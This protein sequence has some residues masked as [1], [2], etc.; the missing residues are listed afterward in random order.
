MNR[1]KDN[2]L[3]FYKRYTPQGLVNDRP[4]TSSTQLILKE[5]RKL[6]MKVEHLIGTNVFKLTYK[7]KERNFHFQNPSSNSATSMFISSSKRAT[8]NLLQ[9]NGIS[10]PKGFAIK[11]NDPASFKKEVY[12]ALQKP[13]VVKPDKGTQGKAISVGINNFSEYL[14]ALKK[15][16]NFS[17]QKDA[18]IVVEEQL[19]GYEEYRV[20]TTKQ[21]VI[22][23]IKR[24]PA[25]IVGDGVSNIRKLIKN[26]NLDP[27]RGDPRDHPPLFRID[28]DVE[29]KEYLNKQN[30]TW[31]TVPPKGQMIQLR[32]VSNISMGGD[33]IDYT[34]KVHNS[35]KTI[36]L[37]AV[38]AIP[39]LELGG[40]DFMS[41][42]ITK[43]QTPDIYAIIEVNNS[44]GIDIHDY[45]FVG[46]KRNAG[47]EF[48]N[49]LFGETF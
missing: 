24:I 34:D 22:G 30:M 26:K 41:K 46:E 25:N 44:P 7:G 39:G 8:R 38:N 3:K 33:S 29:M 12:K 6:G 4:I 31:M 1:D 9:N 47:V 10:I 27:R 18:W 19:V 40:V 43:K 15:A 23:I 45:P 5:A 35:V 36:S 37:K 42:D 2:G 20:L 28:K 21:K 32:G 16:A 48:L 17:K 11:M 14:I 49:V 13:L